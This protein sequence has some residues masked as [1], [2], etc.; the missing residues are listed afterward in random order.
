MAQVRKQKI[1]N[2]NMYEPQWLAYKE[3]EK[4]EKKTQKKT[5]HTK[6]CFSS[7]THLV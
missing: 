6:K 7:E 1:K 5:K 4:R 2:I 3:K